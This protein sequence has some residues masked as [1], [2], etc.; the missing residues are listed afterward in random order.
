MSA[1]YFLFAWA[2]WTEYFITMGPLVLAIV[3]HGFLSGRR[4]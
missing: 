3:A 4:R 2:N 1:V